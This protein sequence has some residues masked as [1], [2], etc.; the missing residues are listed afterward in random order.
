MLSKYC[1]L[2]AVIFT[3][4]VLSLNFN[5]SSFDV[6]SI[7]D[8]YTSSAAADGVGALKSD[9]KSQI[10][11]SVSCPT[12]DTTGILELNISRAKFSSLNPNK[13]S[14]EPPSPS[15]YYYIN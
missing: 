11:K 2:L 5:V 14:K 10:V 7:S 13:S 1:F 4:L 12:A 6:I 3:M 15:Y 9:T 8:G